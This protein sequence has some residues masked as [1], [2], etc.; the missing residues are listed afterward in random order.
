MKP[1]K[2]VEDV[3]HR[4]PYEQ[5]KVARVMRDYQ[6]ADLAEEPG[7][8]ALLAKME[9]F[10][11]IYEVEGDGSTLADVQSMV[12]PELDEYSDNNRQFT[13]VEGNRSVEV[14]YEPKTAPDAVT[15][16]RKMA[17]VIAIIRT[18]LA[19]PE[20][21]QAPAPELL[22]GDKLASTKLFEAC[23][24]L[25]QSAF[26]AG[27]GL[28]PNGTVARTMLPVGYSKVPKKGEHSAGVMNSC[29]RNYDAYELPE[30]YKK[31]SAEAKYGAEGRMRMDVDINY[32][33]DAAGVKRL[34]G[35]LKR[36][37]SKTLKT[38][39]DQATLWRDG[40][41]SGV[42]IRSGPYLVRARI[43]VETY[44]RAAGYK[45]VKVTDKRYVAAINALVKNIKAQTA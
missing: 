18:N 32:F 22:E 15:L 19:N 41:N 43:R 30:G 35:A 7:A 14:S 5:S 36:D 1:L 45:D 40:Y 12:L 16:L 34:F 20:L 3:I 28:K 13:I 2:E 39:A 11:E 26:I 31:T 24:I 29:N 44:F 38:Q 10:W 9:E 8:R 27:V 23:A 6:E 17:V 25:D 33:P 42:H 4:L 37:K 21:N